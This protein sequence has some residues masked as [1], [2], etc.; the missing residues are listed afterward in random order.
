MV[1]S[2]PLTQETPAL[3][4]QRGSKAQWRKTPTEKAQPA[5]TEKAFSSASK[6]DWR[7]KDPAPFRGWD[8]WQAARQSGGPDRDK[9]KYAMPASLQIVDIVDP[10]A[11]PELKEETC[12]EFA[13]PAKGQPYYLPRSFT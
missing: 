8:R 9:W 5:A 13:T 4:P 3:R 7:K 1:A 12:K 6:S 10:N 11:E 2:I